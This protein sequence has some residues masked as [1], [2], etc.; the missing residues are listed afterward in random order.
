MNIADVRTVF[1]REEPNM[2]G[3]RV[4]GE[5]RRLGYWP[6]WVMEAEPERHQPRR[7]TRRG[8]NGRLRK[9]RELCGAS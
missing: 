6:E 2:A 4:I 8:H 3:L 7:A 5:I 1:A 9:R